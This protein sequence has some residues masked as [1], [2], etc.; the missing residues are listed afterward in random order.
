MFYVE[1]SIE[2]FIS[3][4][5]YFYNGKDPSFLFSAVQFSLEYI[6]F[7]SRPMCHRC[8]C[9]IAA[10]VCHRCPCETSTIGD[11]FVSVDERLTCRW[12]WNFFSRNTLRTTPSVDLLT[13]GDGDS[14]TY[15]HSTNQ[16]HQR[17]FL[18]WSTFWPPQDPCKWSCQLLFQP[19]GHFLLN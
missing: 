1:L 18:S 15:I 16:Q 3:R 6:C 10:H 12:T 13:Y 19:K 7:F 8:P 14:S 9:V 11:I 5:V 2:V 17:C 4:K